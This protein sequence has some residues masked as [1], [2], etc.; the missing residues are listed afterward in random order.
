MNNRDKG[1][2]ERP[3]KRPR[4]GKSGQ[5]KRNEIRKLRIAKPHNRI[6]AVDSEDN[7]LCT[8]WG[9]RIL[10]VDTMDSFL[11]NSECRL[12]NYRKPEYTEV[13][14]TIRRITKH[15]YPT[16]R[17]FDPS[18][19]LRRRPVPSCSRPAPLLR[20]RTMSLIP[21]ASFV[22]IRLPDLRA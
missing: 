18:P 15:T 19:P 6:R 7:T 2:Q 9:Q 13:C 20:G 21:F 22:L 11:Q 8:I 10:N 17:Q 5:G 3:A 12:E 16:C 14:K 1:S 4:H